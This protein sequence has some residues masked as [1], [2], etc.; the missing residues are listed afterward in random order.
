MKPY[1]YASI[2][3]VDVNYYVSKQVVPA[4]ARV[5]EFF[6][7]TEENLLTIEK[8]GEKL[9]SLMDYVGN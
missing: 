9:K 1:V 5:L 4:A 8:K 6:G 3:E 2:N 7:I